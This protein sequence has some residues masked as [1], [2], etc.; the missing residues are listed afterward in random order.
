MFLADMA[1]FYPAAARAAT[2]SPV[3]TRVNPIPAS[4]AR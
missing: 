2:A 3:A 1:A 4:P